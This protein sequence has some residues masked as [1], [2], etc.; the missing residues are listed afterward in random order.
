MLENDKKNYKHT[1]EKTS[2]KNLSL[3]RL[4]EEG[5]FQHAPE[6]LFL[7]G[8]SKKTVDEVSELIDTNN[9]KK[10]G[11]II[12]ALYPADMAD[13]LNNLD[14]SRLFIFLEKMGDSLEPDVFLYLDASLKEDSL[15]II[16]T[17]QFASSFSKLDSNDVIDILE[18]LDEEKRQEFLDAISAEE[19]G[20]IIKNLSYPEHSAGRMMQKKIAKVKGSFSVGETIAYVKSFSDLPDVVTDIYVTDDKNKLQGVISLYDLLRSNMDESIKNVITTKV[21]SVLYN[22]D[23]EDIANLFRHYNLFSAPVTNEN[24]ELLGHISVDD[25]LHVIREE[26]EEDLASIGGVGKTSFYDGSV[27]TALMR[28]GGLSA[29]ILNATVLAYV[30]QYFLSK[31]SLSKPQ[32]AVM[33]AML[34]IVGALSGSSGIQTATVIIRALGIRDLRFGNV[35]Q[36]I[37]K[38]QSIG[39]INGLVIALIFLIFSFFSFGFIYLSLTLALSLLLNMIWTNT[40]SAMLP[41]LLKRAGLDPAINAGPILSTVADI[42]GYGIYLFL[43]Y[44]FFM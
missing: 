31:I 27:R 24:Q 1:K 4:S 10:L 7:F 8:V 13:L 26:A 6:D 22:M 41:I 25:V 9:Q 2:E 15:E 12:S 19:R 34:P 18:D 38:E 35:I 40:I 37:F 44:M 28:L 33:M 32:T 5:L 20:D 36:T 43:I 3:D 21:H 23:R 17:K 30:I 29:P 11:E 42:S 14:N 16:D 39:A